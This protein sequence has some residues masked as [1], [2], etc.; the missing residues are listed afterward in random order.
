MCAVEDR[1][2]PSLAGFWAIFCLIF[3]IAK[4]KFLVEI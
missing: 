4:R 2:K 3:S 1:E